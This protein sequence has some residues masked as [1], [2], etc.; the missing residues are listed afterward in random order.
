MTPFIENLKRLKPIYLEE[1]NTLKLLNRVDRKYLLNKS[2]YLQFSEEVARLGY[3][4]LTV[5]NCIVQNYQ[6]TYYDNEKLQFYL[7]HHN[8]RLN[9]VKVRIRTYKTTGDTFLEVKQRV[10]SGG[11]TRKKRIP[12]EDN[13]FLGDRETKFIDKYSKIPANELQPV[14]QTDFERVTLT[15]D[16]WKER[17]TID[18]NLKIIFKEKN[19]HLQDIVIIEVKK[20]KNSAFN[21]ISNYLKGKSIRPI[22]L[23]KYCLAIAALNPNIKHNQFKPILRKLNIDNDGYN[24]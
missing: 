24:A 1:I 6:T 16:E 12:L 11:E 18:F 7:D 9:R 2:E 17:V 5:N 13:L 20:E 21:G 14:A 8:K 10:N 15:S 23:S 22:P 19:I 3:R 4:V